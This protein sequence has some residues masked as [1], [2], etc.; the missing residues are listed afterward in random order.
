C[1]NSL[2]LEAVANTAVESP[3]AEAAGGDL[4]LVGDVA[5]DG[6]AGRHHAGDAAA[7]LDR[8]TVLAGVECDAAD[9]DGV[10]AV[11]EAL[12]EID[13]QVGCD[14]AFVVGL[15][16]PHQPRA[17]PDDALVE[18]AELDV[19]AIGIGGGGSNI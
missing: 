13:I 6:E 3:A 9:V 17:G 1:I 19:D 7:D 12:Q 11:G 4:V 10:V 2:P 14:E 18:R 8:G 15:E 16:R 5:I